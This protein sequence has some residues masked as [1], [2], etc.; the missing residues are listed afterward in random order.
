MFQKRWVKFDGDSI[1]YYNNEKVRGVFYCLS[2]TIAVQQC[3]RSPLV[4][5]KLPQAIAHISTL[6]SL[7][8]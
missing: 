8:V 3:H 4:L 5:Q 6:F 1:S 7:N 2:L